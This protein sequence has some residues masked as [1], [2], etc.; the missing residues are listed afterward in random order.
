MKLT[1]KNVAALALPPGKTDVVY[2]DDTL[3]GFGCRLRGDS[4]S[5]LIQYRAGP[6]QHREALGDVR[7]VT[8]D[9]ARKVARQRFAQIELGVD[10]AAEKAKA[11]VEAAAA[12]LT[13]GAVSERYLDAK[14]RALRHNSFRAARLHLTEHW[15]PLA[16]RPLGSIGR[17]DVAAQLQTLVKERGRIAA[18]RSRTNLS[19][20]FAWALGEGLVDSNP[21]IGT[22]APDAGVTPRER[23]LTDRELAAIW[24]ACDDS[25]GRIVRLMIL[26]AC[27]RQEIGG[28]KWSEIDTDRGSVTIDA[29][30][31]KNHRK[32]TLTLPPV[33]LAILASVSRRGEAVFSGDDA[34]QSWSALKAR[35]DAAS[36][37]SAWTLHDLRRTV[38]TKM[39]DLG[40]QPHIIEQI[41]NHQSGHKR[42]PAGIY[43]RSSYD[44]EVRATLA[45]WADHVLAVVE[46]RAPKLLAF[47]GSMT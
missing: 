41:L 25:S 14:R 8:L 7:K 47:P 4:R 46:G 26:T 34:F 43:N 10:P 1:Q 24:N 11:R 42:G 40:V 38:A 36:G 45:L 44:R 18:A 5:W 39:A 2:W 35:L 6:R 3:P 19:A 37:V 20:L 21:V 15:K 9:D 13:L 29:A 16:G 12:A 17:A 28:L 32:L 22:N 27:R 23:V 30:R 33:A 31:T